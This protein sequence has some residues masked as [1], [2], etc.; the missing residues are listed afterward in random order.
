[1]GDEGDG[2]YTVDPDGGVQFDPDLLTPSDDP[3]VVADN[4]MKYSGPDG[5]VHTVDLSDPNVSVWVP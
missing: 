3:G 1:M 5:S 2:G 4:T